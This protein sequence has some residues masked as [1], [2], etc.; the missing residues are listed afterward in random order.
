MLAENE[1]SRPRLAWI[2]NFVTSLH[3][4]YCALRSMFSND[5]QGPLAIRSAIALLLHPGRG[6]EYR[7][8]PVCLSVCVCVSVCPQAYLMEP[9]ERSARNYVCG[10]PVAVARSSSGDVALCY[11]LAVLWMTSRLAV[12]GATP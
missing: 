1:V 7:D 6:A 4:I 3:L 12:M 2:Q 10:S 11:V 5:A 9:L 8:Q